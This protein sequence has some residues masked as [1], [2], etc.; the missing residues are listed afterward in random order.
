MRSLTLGIDAVNLRAGGGVTHLVE[1]IAAADPTRHGV[2]RVSIWAG[3]RTLAAMADRPWLKK[4]HL[5]VLDGGLIRRATWQRFQLSRA[6]RAAGCDLLFV[7]GGSF[8]GDFKPVV[9]MSQ[10]L[11]PFDLREIRRYGLSGTAL[12]MLLLRFT[13]SRTFRRAD[14]VIFLTAAAKD[15]VL[16]VTGP[17]ACDC[18]VIPHGLNPRFLQAP[19]PQRAIETYS[20]R[21][22]F[23]L[24]YVSIVDQY[25][26][27]WQVVEALHALRLDGWPLALELVGPAYPPA[28]VKLN[29]AIGRYDPQG[30]WVCYHG[31]VSYETLHHLYRQADLGLLASS[32]ETISIILLETMGA[33]LPV[34]CS[35]AKP[36]RELL[37]SAGVYFNPEKPSD[38]AC[39]LRELIASPSLRTE[40]AKASFAAA[41]SFDW[42]RCADETFAFLARIARQHRETRSA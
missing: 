22:P 32:C 2:S 37:G 15:A 18:P 24:L 4:H 40:K 30:E 5:A 17:L 33:G 23:R 27:Q 11:L 31:A 28:L 41:Q 39:A 19:K 21:K 6:A 25:K 16:Q 20:A 1:F 9:T 14:G 13:Q 34:A 42:K 38:I 35:D 10:N 7:P 3:A 12:K 29:A 8:A 36:L 26:H